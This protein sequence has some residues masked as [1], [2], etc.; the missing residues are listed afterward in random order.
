MIQY[1]PFHVDPWQDFYP[2]GLTFPSTF[3]N[4][5]LMHHADKIYIRKPQ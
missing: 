3:K 2:D 1:C 4:R 5:N